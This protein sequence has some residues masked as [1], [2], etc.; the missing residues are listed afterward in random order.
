MLVYIYVADVDA[1]FEQARATGA[2]IVEP[3]ADQVYGDRRYTALDPEGHR[4]MFAQYVRDVP[5]WWEQI[6]SQT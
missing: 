2:T 4:W 6:E 3:P 5:N 1:H